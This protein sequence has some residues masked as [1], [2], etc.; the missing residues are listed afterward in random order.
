MK[1]IFVLLIALAVQAQAAEP[2]LRKIDSLQ[3]VLK[4]DVPDSVR[5]DA[6]FQIADEY[7]NVIEDKARQEANFTRA[8]QY[9]NQCITLSEKCNY[10]QG[11]GDAYYIISGVHD[12][13]GK[14]IE[15]LE[16]G[17]KAL[18]YRIESGD[19]KKVIK[20]LFHLG[21]ICGNL[22]DTEQ[23]LQYYF[24]GLIRE[25][26]LGGVEAAGIYHNVGMIYDAAGKRKEAITYTKKALIIN[27]KPGGNKNWLGINC[28]MLGHYLSNNVEI[29]NDEALKYFDR[30]REIFLSLGYKEQFGMAL[31]GLGIMLSHSGKHREGVDTMHKALAVFREIQ[32]KNGIAWTYNCL[33][34]CYTRQKKYREAA[35]SLDSCLQLCKELGPIA[36]RNVYQRLYQLDSTSGNTASAYTH[37]RLYINLRDSINNTESLQALA[38]H[39]LRS[40]YSKKKSG[41]KPNRKRKKHYKRLSA[42][43][44]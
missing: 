12:D 36:M 6:Y 31:V 23:Q 15:A 35:V 42:T 16:W 17:K 21:I 27:E 37:Y 5:A 44:F 19:E 30:G 40:E 2:N 7:W 39:Q 43:L 8:M 29:Y 18:Q 32:N 22:R 34:L 1:T 10:R 38:K 4:N 25:E 33:G 11:V 13:R 28:L 14:H 41:K 20:V 9:A 24:D 3:N 26:R